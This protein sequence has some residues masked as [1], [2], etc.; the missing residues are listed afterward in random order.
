MNLKKVPSLTHCKMPKNPGI[1]LKDFQKSPLTERS[2]TWLFR[3]LLKK[4]PLY[5]RLKMAFC[6]GI[7]LDN[8]QKR[9][10][11]YM[12]WIWRLSHALQKVPSYTDLKSAI[13]PGISSK[14]YQSKKCPLIYSL[15]NGLL[16]RKKINKNCFTY[17]AEPRQSFLISKKSPHHHVRY[18]TKTPK[19][20]WGIP[21]T[22][23]YP[24][25]YSFEN[26]KMSR[27]FGG[28]F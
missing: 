10:L 19:N 27:N 8:F 3:T 9:S 26:G 2:E 6:P 18:D 13:C 22:K 11:T 16:P 23:N 12:V 7:S 28:F 25:I 17:K 1:S 5:T 15:K 20:F 14:K 21:L 4:V 24:L